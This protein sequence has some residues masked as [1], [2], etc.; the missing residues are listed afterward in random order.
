MRCD[1]PALS[2]T[3]CH[4]PRATLGAAPT[5]AACRPAEHTPALVYRGP[6]AVTEAAAPASVE[7]DTRRF[8]GPWQ[9]AERRLARAL[10]ARAADPDPEVRTAAARVQSQIGAGGSSSLTARA[11]DDAVSFA[12]GQLALARSARLAPLVKRLGLEGMLDEIER[13]TNDLAAAASLA[14]EEEAALRER[15]AV[16]AVCGASGVFE[17]VHAR[18]ERA[19]EKAAAAVAPAR[20]PTDAA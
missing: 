1:P 13:R 8:D 11:A 16:T 2:P 9:E 19:G 17:R 4:D 6:R 10:S 7:H 5:P 18:I 3:P 12:R 14:A 20:A 15:H